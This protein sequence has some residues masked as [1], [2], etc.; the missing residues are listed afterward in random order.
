MQHW[1]LNCFSTIYFRRNEVILHTFSEI[2]KRHYINLTSRAPIPFTTV[3][4]STLR[5]TQPPIQCVTEDLSLGVKRLG[6]E[7]DHSPAS[8]AEVKEC[9]ELYLHSPSTHLL[10]GSQLEA[11]GQIYLYLTHLSLVT[12]RMFLNNRIFS[13]NISR[14]VSLLASWQNHY[15]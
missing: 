6:R 7:V 1:K 10:R 9:V 2:F 5:P 13:R 3:S 8:S 12:D 4:K 14:F 15:F 11:Q